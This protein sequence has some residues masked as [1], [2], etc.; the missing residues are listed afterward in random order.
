MSNVENVRN[1]ENIFFVKK[2]MVIKKPDSPFAKSIKTIDI[3]KFK[4]YVEIDTTYLNINKVVVVEYENIKD[5]ED[6]LFKSDNKNV[7]L[8][9]KNMAIV[10]DLDKLKDCFTK[11][12][13]IY[14]E[15]LVLA[16]DIVKKITRKIRKIISDSL[17]DEESYISIEEITYL[18]E[19]RYYLNELSLNYDMSGHFDGMDFVASY[20][21]NQIIKGV[22]EDEISDTIMTEYQSFEFYDG[23][24][25]DINES[26]KD[27]LIYLNKK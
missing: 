12:F 20:L 16:E 9:L 27:F 21:I 14:E 18:Q 13:D 24:W 6:I 3:D 22:D 1:L 5:L 25:S 11:I 19:L 15:A 2:G 17:T 8:Y 7:S 10:L 23:T 4:F 26:I